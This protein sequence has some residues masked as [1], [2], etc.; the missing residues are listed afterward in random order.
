M[1]MAHCTSLAEPYDG[2]LSR[3]LITF[4]ATGIVFM[5]L[6]GTLLGVVNLL[7]IS[8]RR[9]PAAADAAWIQAHGHAQIFG[10]LGTFIL[11]IGSYAIPRL[12]LSRDP[13]WIAWATWALWTAGVALR[14]AGGITEWHWRTLFPL[15]AALELF[16]ATAFFASVFLPRPRAPQRTW[17][18]S[19]LMIEAAAAGM[20]VTLGVNLAESLTL[21]RS[22]A[23]PVFPAAFNQRFLAA[24]AWGFI[25]PF[26]WG[27]G[28]RWIPPLLGLRKAH[29]PIL[30]PALLLLMAGAALDAPIVIAV[31][32]VVF[33]IALRIFEPAQKAPKLRGVH[34]SAGAFL[35]SAFAWMILAAALGIVAVSAGAG[36]AGASRHALTVGFMVV[37]VFCI[38]SRMLPA[39]FGVRR[40]FSNRLMFTS[41]LLISAGCALRVGS[42]VVAY[43]HLSQAAWSVLPLSAILEMTAI[44]LFAFNMLMSL[45]TGTPYDTY[46]ESLAWGKAVR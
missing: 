34:P 30:L 5:L 19:L 38:G 14:W 44:V 22:A 32:C 27:F 2:R 15:G 33:V 16:A 23:S 31:A 36:F 24:A 42:E 3:R 43:G 21:A 17:R 45:T 10:W 28:T 12:R 7:T 11:G 9:A 35:R 20:V 46:L 26:I 37:T 40:L 4:V 41:L 13:G 29:N 1:A 6:P 8:A 25:V 18:S 39:F